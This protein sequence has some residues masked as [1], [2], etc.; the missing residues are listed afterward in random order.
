MVRNE[1]VNELIPNSLKHYVYLFCIYIINVQETESRVVIVLQKP[2]KAN[3][4]A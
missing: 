2:K 1:I 4:S 3:V